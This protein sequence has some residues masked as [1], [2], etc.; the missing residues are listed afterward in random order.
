MLRVIISLNSCMFWFFYYKYVLLINNS[1]LKCN[2]NCPGYYCFEDKYGQRQSWVYL[3]ENKC[4]G[5]FPMDP[6][7]F[8]VH[9]THSTLPWDVELFEL[10][11]QALLA[12][13]LQ[14]GKE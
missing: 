11:Q 6:S 2:L 7:K 5:V 10:Y 14:L 3:L 9:P 8:T 1:F 4:A 13:G 12:L